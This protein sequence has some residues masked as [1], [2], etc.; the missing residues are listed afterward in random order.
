VQDIPDMGSLG[1]MLGKQGYSTS[2]PYRFS[3]AC[4]SISQGFCI[5]DFW[6][7]LENGRV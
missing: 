5:I 3:A 6:S 1:G 4:L 7:A 2:N